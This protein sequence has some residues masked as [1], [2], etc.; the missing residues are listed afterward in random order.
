MIGV[1]KSPH[2]NGKLSHQFAS[3][4]MFR[5]VRIVKELDQP[6][7]FNKMLISELA[8]DVWDGMTED[9]IHALN[10]LLF[11]SH[12]HNMQI[13]L[14]RGRHADEP[15]IPLFN[16]QWTSQISFD[17]SWLP[18]FEFLLYLVALKQLCII[19]FWF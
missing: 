3:A 17:W 19:L 5:T 12:T 8:P 6:R 10:S 9:Q 1:L 4:F 16:L 14:D 11:H 15:T 7:R 2:Q 18:K 13:G